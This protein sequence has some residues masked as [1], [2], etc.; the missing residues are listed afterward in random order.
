MARGTT[1]HKVD[2]ATEVVSCREPRDDELS[3]MEHFAKHSARCEYCRDPYTAYRED[4][5]LCRKGL[6]YAKDVATYLY[7]KG[8]KPFSRID[9]ENG[10][11]VQVLVPAGCEVIGLLIKAFDKGMKLDS[12]R[13]V[14]VENTRTHETVE[15]PV[16]VV[17]PSSPSSPSSP[18]RRREYHEDRLRERRYVRD[19]YDVVEIIPH[20]SRSDR[21]ERIVYRDDRVDNRTRY[22]E[23][24]ERPKSIIYTGGKGSLYVRDEEE[25]RRREYR[26]P[27]VIVTEPGQRFTTRR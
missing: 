4:R 7:A 8:G 23:R 2:F 6:S 18:L 21:R 26:Q 24:R 3:V 15:K 13:V 27:V 17:S 10:Q 12:S 25:R 16:R 22:E 11:R 19:D 14:V 5:P 9:K 20:S 1:T